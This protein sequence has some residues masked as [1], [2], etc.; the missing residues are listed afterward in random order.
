MRKLPHWSC[1]LLAI[2]CLHGAAAAPSWQVY[3]HENVLG[4]SLE[5]KF[6]APTEA[7]AARAETAA[8]G[9][10]DRLAR[11]LSGYDAGSEFRQWLLS[12][13][14]PRR[15]SPELFEILRLFDEWRQRTD[16]A[17]DASAE[18]AGR[19]WREAERT[20]RTPSENEIAAVISEVRQPHWRLDPA[21][22]TA[23]HLTDVP[24]MLNSFAKSYI[25]DRA[26]AAAMTAGHLEAAVVNIGGDLVVR[27]VHPDEVGIAD[28]AAD[29]ENDRPIAE[30]TVRD[31]A[32]ATSGGYRRGGEIAGRWYS[33]LVDP[34]TGRPVDHV[35][36]ATV[37]ARD[38]VEAGA[39]A[40]AFCVM[41]PE[42]SLRLAAAREG[43]ECLLVTADGKRV[44]S[45]GWTTLE[46]NGAQ[47]PPSVFAAVA[48]AADAN[49]AAESGAPD[50]EVG[51]EFEIARIAGGRTRR[52]FVAAWIEDENG[53]PLRTLALW[54]NGN[55][56]LP[57]LR[58]WS[59]GDQIRR[60][61]E[62]SSI[63]SISSATRAPGKYSLRWDGRDNAGKPVAPG[64]Y[65]V[66]IEAAREH[67]THQLLRRQIDVAAP[68]QTF[69][70]EGGVELSTASI[71]LRHPA[72]SR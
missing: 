42:Q 22:R 46:R 66:L 28:P 1:W 21:T 14:E 45:A 8:L 19:L 40:T 57:E 59:H 4:T 10:I 54:F 62:G 67:G 11:I 68:A 52:P 29:A 41:T 63:L 50:F 58:T 17:L 72:Q 23:N 9:E 30:L 5:L 43:V 71:E 7:D 12:R 36:S 37:V 38:A 35:R 15:V 18:A 31:R 47:S 3:Q 33:H 51:I 44:M 55:R 60:Q 24:L 6:V 32:V 39:L 25:I 34:R 53:F 56:W 27:G 70:L 65:T 64:K 2:A 48:S 13:N 26:C 69:A 61:T 16:G 49:T 20:Q